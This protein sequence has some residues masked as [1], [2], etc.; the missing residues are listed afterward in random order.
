MHRNFGVCPHCT[1]KGLPGEIWKLNEKTPSITFSDGK[2][3][4]LILFSGP[5]AVPAPS[6]GLL[7]N[8]VVAQFSYIHDSL[9]SEAHRAA[10]LLTRPGESFESATVQLKS[11]AFKLADLLKSVGRLSFQYGF[12]G[13]Q[14]W[15]LRSY[16]E[17]LQD[18]S[19][20][21]RW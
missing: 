9:G 3:F 5:D 19:R 21:S 2:S 7:A 16:D 13:K 10:V 4:H 15:E 17:L 14:L 20:F 8:R 11:A 6:G 12:D 1:A 18:R